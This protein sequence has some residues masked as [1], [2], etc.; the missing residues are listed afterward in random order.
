MT[1]SLTL[2]EVLKRTC[3]KVRT[4]AEVRE[5]LETSDPDFQCYHNG[6]FIFD[7][8][9]GDDDFDTWGDE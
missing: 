7:D 4:V 6:L 9:F 3:L 1:T 8:G 2:E 5:W